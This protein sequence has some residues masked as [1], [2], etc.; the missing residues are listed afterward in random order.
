[1]D[2]LGA[3]FLGSGLEQPQHRVRTL[4]PLR[5]EPPGLGRVCCRVVVGLGHVRIAE[6]FFQVRMKIVLIL[7]GRLACSH[8]IRLFGC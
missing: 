3:Q 1:M 5:F 4:G 8:D 7:S 6:H 2:L